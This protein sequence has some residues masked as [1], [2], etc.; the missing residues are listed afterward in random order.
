MKY[1]KLI[2][3]L[4]VMKELEIKPNF[5]ALQREYHV[6]RHT[7]KKLYENDGVVARKQREKVSKWDPYYDEICIL[8]N[9]VGVSKRSV[10]QYLL[11]KYEDNI[12]GTYN[13]FKAYTLRKGIVCKCNTVSH[14]LYEVDPGKQLQFDWK[15]SLTIHLKDKTEINF[16]VFSATLGYSREHVFIYSRTKTTE[17]LIRCI[18]ETYRR[19]GG[20]TEEALTDNMSAIVGGN[21]RKIN[22]K[23]NQLMKDLNIHLRLCKVKV[24]Q[25][26]GKVED[27]N[28]FVKWIAPYDYELESEDDLINIIEEV[29]T[30]QCNNQINTS[31]KMPPAI[32]FLKE[33]E[34]LKPLSRDVLLDSYI[35][36]HRTQVVPATLLIAYEGN[37]YSVPQRYINKRV[38]IYPIDDK[39][40]IYHNKSLVTIHTISQ[41][42][43]NYK[44]EHYKEALAS[45]IKNKEIDIDEMAQQNL[46]RFENLG[47]NKGE[48]SHDNKL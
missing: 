26:K 36:E 10:Y 7:I 35:Q 29:I 23:V 27:S 1:Q 8:M 25:T 48:M 4:R 33:K 47:I 22:P 9:K 39:L 40:Y 46:K 6:D 19:L 28:K 38:D 20:V 5:S 44:A 45:S 18:I 11:Q 3:R 42:S 30:R 41:K 32:L 34:Y 24:P 17:D 2:G 37:K 16:N 12:P 31:T 43:V 21:G 14:V 15:E 13:G